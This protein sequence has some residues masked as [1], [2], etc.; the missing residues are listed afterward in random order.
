MDYGLLLAVAGICF[1]GCFVQAACGFGFA[2]VAMGM[3]GMLLP[4]FGEA[5]GL[6]NLL[7][8]FVSGFFMLRLRG[9]VHWKTILWP[10]LSHIP[11][12]FVMVRIVAIN[13][14]G[15]VQRLLGIALV[16]LA[17]YFIFL[18]GRLRIPANPVSGLIIGVLTGTLGGLFCMSGIPMALYLLSMEE[19]EE[20]LGTIQS[21]FAL[22]AVYSCFLHGFSGFYTPLV[23][24]LILPCLAT[25]VLGT[26]L[27]KALFDRIDQNGMKKLIYAF[28]L[29]SG[30]YFVFF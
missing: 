13:P 10:L 7:L 25:G 20:Y 14:S 6:A 28:M 12:S 9:S 29:I 5:A 16:L 2:V 23:L 24:R 4:S 18:Q 27:G 8:L 21:F 17:C 22:V 3:L 26:L 30:V 1:A 19:K 15:I 11:I